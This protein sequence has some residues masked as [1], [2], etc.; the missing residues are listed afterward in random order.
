MSPAART[1]PGVVVWVLVAVAHRCHRGDGPPQRIAESLDV[2]FGFA[3]F[4]EVNEGGP[5]EDNDDRGHEDV[6]D[7]APT[8]DPEMGAECLTQKGHH[9]HQANGA[10]KWRVAMEPQGGAGVER[11]RPPR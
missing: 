11:R 7:V 9:A 1:R 8:V 4:R 2:R 5:E 3:F 6:I 10:G